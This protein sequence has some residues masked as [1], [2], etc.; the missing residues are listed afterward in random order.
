M[1]WKIKEYLD[2]Y[3]YYNE[4]VSVYSL[5]EL[6][7]PLALKVDWETSEYGSSNGFNYTIARFRNIFTIRLKKVTSIFIYIALAAFFM[8]IVLLFAKG[9]FLYGIVALVSFLLITFMASRLL[10]VFVFKKDR[11][12][13]YG[14]IELPFTRVGKYE[15]VESLDDIYAIQVIRFRVRV[16]SDESREII[17][18]AVLNLI[19]K[20]G[21]RVNLIIQSDVVLLCRI[22]QE[23][24]KFLDT[25]VWYVYTNDLPR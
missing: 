12:I 7:D 18:N 15:L 23:L 20:D 16:D 14:A 8:G 3:E 10:K 6:N 19:L 17:D 22:A 2:K 21:S 11:D 5:E 4:F 25:P 9:Y 1:F 24:S 13:A